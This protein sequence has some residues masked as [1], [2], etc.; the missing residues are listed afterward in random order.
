MKIGE[1]SVE[2]FN[3]G[4]LEKVRRKRKKYLDVKG[5]FL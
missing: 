5:D 1:L 3:Y 4:S 2:L